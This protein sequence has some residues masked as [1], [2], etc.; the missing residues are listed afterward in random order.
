M[1]YLSL[2]PRSVY[3]LGDG[4]LFDEIIAHMLTSAANLRVITQAYAGESVLLADIYEYRPDVILLNETDR[5]GCEEMLELLPRMPL[6]ADLRVI[7]ISLTHE[8]IRIWD[9]PAGWNNKSTGVSNTL[10]GVENWNALLD[11]VDGKQL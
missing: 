5:F 11:L 2:V 9:Q 3:L 1:S 6:V 10:Q 7:V 4:L 8:S